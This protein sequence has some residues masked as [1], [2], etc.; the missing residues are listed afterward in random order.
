MHP[1][2]HFRNDTSLPAAI[3]TAATITGTFRSLEQKI[4]NTK[5][6]TN[7]ESDAT[8]RPEENG[9][10]WTW[11]R[12]FKVRQVDLEII[13]IHKRVNESSYKHNFDSLHDAY[14]QAVK[15]YDRET[16]K[17]FTTD[18]QDMIT[19]SLT[20]LQH[21]GSLHLLWLY[22]FAESIPRENL[23]HIM[24]GEE[25]GDIIK[26]RLAKDDWSGT[27]ILDK[28]DFIIVLAFNY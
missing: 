12:D 20:V 14:V 27:G 23:R 7:A 28:T 26:Q 10:H 16:I 11:I 1:M 24:T 9:D 2:H 17:T 5:E 18:V 15:E 13:D 21:W 4:I 19:D 6:G 25:K 8:E 3:N 22:P